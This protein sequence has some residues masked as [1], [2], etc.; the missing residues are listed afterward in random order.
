MARPLARFKDSNGQYYQ[1]EWQPYVLSSLVN[2]V[3]RKNSENQTNIPLTMSARDGLIDQESYFNKTVASSDLSNYTLLYQ[4]EFAYNH[5][6]SKGYDYGAIHRLTKVSCGAV[7][8]LYFCFNIKDQANID[9]DFLA[10]YFESQ[11]WTRE[12]ASICSKGARQ[13]GA[14]N[15]SVDDFFNIIIYVP[16][17]E[18]QRQVVRIAS[19]IDTTIN[20]ME[21]IVDAWEQRKNGVTQKL[22]SQE[23]RFKAD[24]GMDFPAWNSMNF[25]NVFD[26]ISNNT[27]ARAK[28]SDESGQA[29]NIHYGDIHTKFGEILDLKNDAVPFIIPEVDCSRMMPLQDGDIVIADTAEDNT[30]GK[31]VEVHNVGSN[32][33]YAGLHTIARRPKFK[34][35]PKY[36]GY[37]INSNAY[38]DQLIPYMQGTKLPAISKA[39]ILLTHIAIPSPQEQRKIAECLDA[40]NDVI[41]L[42]KAEL[43]KWREL[44]KGLLQQLFV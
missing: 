5:S 13:H 3:T 20:Q 29:K 10:Y 37:Y 4:G 23:V 18:E 28:L 34:F 38:H 35:A 16:S 26:E 25:G 6:S 2:R 36:L 9:S 39:H 19:S 41:A 40:I 22:F 11:K 33:L 31:A 30:V 32:I 15:I 44:K 17:I 21:S 12:V 24:D 8:P 7:T 14:L 43:E 27:L 42:S 1:A